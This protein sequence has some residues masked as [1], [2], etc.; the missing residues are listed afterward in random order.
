MGAL[1]RLIQS[2]S[3]LGANG[4]QLA[5]AG[6][7]APTRARALDLKVPRPRIFETVRDAELDARLEEKFAQIREEER[8]ILDK[9][10]V[11]D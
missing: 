11:L 4:G 1:S 10:I 5:I 2:I 8:N 9:L 7:M 6:G 3:G